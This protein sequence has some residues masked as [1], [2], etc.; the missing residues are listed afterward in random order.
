M[1][2]ILCMILAG[3]MALSLVGCSKITGKETV[4]LTFEPKGAVMEYKLVANE[5]LVEQIVQTTTLDC[6]GET[7][8]TL[9]EVRKILSEY[10]MIYEKIDGVD[11]DYEETDTEIIE[12]ITIDT[13]NPETV[14]SLIDQGLLPVDGS[15][16][17]I[18]LEQTVA[19]LEAEGWTKK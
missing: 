14:Q 17:L 1:K 2:K 13:T 4:V 12:T 11:Y 10:A 15:T 19:N 5:D 3:V 16:T 18:S 6:S 9:I 7:D 8:E